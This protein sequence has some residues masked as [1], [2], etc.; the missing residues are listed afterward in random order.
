MRFKVI[1]SESKVS[2]YNEIEFVEMLNIQFDLM[3]FSIME[4]VNE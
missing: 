2:Y 3:D 4:E 1:D